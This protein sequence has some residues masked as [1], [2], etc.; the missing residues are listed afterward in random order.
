MPKNESSTHTPFTKKFWKTLGISVLSTLLVYG[1][2]VWATAYLNGCDVFDGGKIGRVCINLGAS[3]QDDDTDE[4]TILPNNADVGIK[5]HVEEQIGK[6]LKIINNHPTKEY[7]LPTRSKRELDSFLSAWQM[8]EGQRANDIEEKGDDI[9]DIDVCE[10]GVAYGTSGSFAEFGVEG[11]EEA[12]YACIGTYEQTFS[13]NSAGTCTGDA[14]ETTTEGACGPAL[15]C[16]IGWGM[17]NNSGGGSS[18]GCT[19]ATVESGCNYSNASSCNANSNCAWSNTPVTTTCSSFNGGMIFNALFGSSS[20][21][22]ADP[23]G[24]VDF[25]CNWEDGVSNTQ[26]RVC[27]DFINEFTFT[28]DIGL[29]IPGCDSETTCTWDA[30][31]TPPEAN[32]LVSQW[33]ECSSG[34]QTRT[35]SCPT[36][37]VCPLAEPASSQSCTTTAT[38][39]KLICGELYRQGLLSEKLWVADNEYADKYID[40]NTV[41]LYQSWARPFVTLME[42]SSIATQMALPFGVAWAEHMAYLEGT[43]DQDNFL[44]R[45]LQQFFLPIHDSLAGVKSI[46]KERTSNAEANVSDIILLIG[47]FVLMAIL[48]LILLAP[49]IIIIGYVLKKQKGL[50][51]IGHFY[52]WLGL[53]LLITLLLPFLF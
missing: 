1:G 53:A 45:S 14:S 3:G 13:A 48:L 47:V 43:I 11:C 23:T 4:I 30:Q 5:D 39:S 26:N 25:G 29:E 28:T 52:K 2:I 6:T 24:C 36:G 42:K 20:F 34:T 49:V 7:F 51:K 9:L 41:A 15:I 18:G 19:F 40:S 16:D 27:S 21:R 31:S 32:W 46:G 22:M 17:N 37:T 50:K 33:E 35:V 12:V 44:G 38:G 8:R 10:K